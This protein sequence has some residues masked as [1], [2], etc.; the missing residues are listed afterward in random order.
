MRKPNAF[1]LNRIGAYSWGT[2]T[3]GS[4]KKT[5]GHRSNVLCLNIGSFVPSQGVTYQIRQRLEPDTCRVSITDTRTGEAPESF[6][7]EP[8]T[9]G[10]Q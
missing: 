1:C 10:C 5:D 6:R 3:S 7:R 8:I 9:Q 4:L 2:I